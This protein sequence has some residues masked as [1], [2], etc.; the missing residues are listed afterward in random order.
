M[1]GVVAN[2]N[3]SRKEYKNARESHTIFIFIKFRNKSSIT[4]VRL[5]EEVRILQEKS[6]SQVKYRHLTK[7]REVITTFN[8][9][10]SEKMEIICTQEDGEQQHQVT[11]CLTTF[12]PENF[13]LVLQITQKDHSLQ[14][15]KLLACTIP[16]KGVN[17]T[18]RPQ[19]LA[20][21]QIEFYLPQEIR[22]KRLRDDYRIDLVNK[23][24]QIIEYKLDPLEEK[25]QSGRGVD[26]SSTGI[27]MIISHQE[28]ATLIEQGSNITIHKICGIPISPAIGGVI[29]HQ[30]KDPKQPNLIQVG[31]MFD[32]RLLE[33]YLLE[34]NLIY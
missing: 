15:D 30:S 16:E 8:Q 6:S 32:H 9:I 21:D 17:F 3:N 31:I 26:L 28:G 33:E 24:F 5:K 25:M 29:R 14:S 27:N 11:A 22:I 19:Q 2:C 23:N 18:A 10:V 12:N 34:I 20:T 1:T 4:Q 7:K 13:S